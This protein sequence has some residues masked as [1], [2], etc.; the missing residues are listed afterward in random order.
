MLK[1]Y[2]FIIEAVIAG[3]TLFTIMSFVL[4][5]ALLETKWFRQWYHRRI[6]N[7]LSKF[8]EMVDED[9]EPQ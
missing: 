3:N 4:M 9:E 2:W 6:M 7:I 1:D 8:G 5:E